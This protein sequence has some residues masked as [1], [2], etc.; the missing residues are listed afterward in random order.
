MKK[1]ILILALVGLCSAGFAQEVVSEDVDVMEMPVNKY[2]VVTNKFFDNWFISG[3]AGVQVL[4]GNSINNR[5]AGDRLTPAINLSVGKWFTPGLGL[6]LQ[7]SGISAKYF[8]TGVGPYSESPKDKSGYYKNKLDYFNLH[9]DILFNVS[10]VLGGYNPDR[11][12]NFVPYAGFGWAHVL[13]T[14]H[15]NSMTLNFGLLNK[16]KVSD[17]VDINLELDGMAVERKFSGV[18]TRKVNVMLGATAGITVNLPQRGWQPAPDIDAILANNASKLDAVNAALAQQIAE[19]QRLKNQLAS[20]PAPKSTTTTVVELTDIPQSIFFEIG[21]SVMP[22]KQI[23]NLKQ[24]ADY[25][26]ANPNTNVTITGYADSSTGTAVWN[27]QLSENRANT[28]A[29]ELGKL[30][31]DKSRM[32]VSGMG[33]V[34]ILSPADFDRRVILEIK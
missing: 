2:K 32:T 4:F 6:R 18:S 29:D 34:D 9:G 28:V 10:N 5:G 13:D 19:N 7:G 14:P 21:S 12:Y 20:M 27:K 30:G 22:K 17:I 24:V 8:T 16:F 1:S 23:V 31:V 11:V 15:S 25:M 3:G 33:G 26:N